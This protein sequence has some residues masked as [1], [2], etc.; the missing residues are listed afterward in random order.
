MI[1]T[2]TF[3]RLAVV[4]VLLGLLLLAT[5]APAI[6]AQPEAGS[7]STGAASVWN[8]H[9][10]PADVPV[11]IA[12]LSDGLGGYETRIDWA[13]GRFSSNE[14]DVVIDI[15]D[16]LTNGGT[17][18]QA[19]DDNTPGL[20][21]VGTD[22]VKFGAYSWGDG[23]P[24]GNMSDGQLATVSLLPTATCGAAALTVDETLLVDIVGTEIPLTAQNGSTVQVYSQ[25]DTS[26][27]GAFI[28]SQD[29]LAVVD[30]LGP[31]PAGCTAGYQFDANA[32]GGAFIN[33]QDVLAVVDNLGPTG[34]Q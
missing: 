33:S 34:C 12:G 8:G 29:V 24:P 11:S 1:G 32:D 23:N 22:T 10:C 15:G 13:A 21:A 4:T 31:R 9:N 16:Y 2:R 6:P 18:S 19:G 17:R 20:K 27:G 14:N 25:Y 7:V 3:R 5:A 28:N 30:H 26:G